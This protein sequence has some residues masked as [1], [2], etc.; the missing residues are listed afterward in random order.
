MW[1][2]HLETLVGLSKGYSY[3]KDPKCWEWFEKVHEYTWK[4]FPDKKNG[5]WFGYLNR[6]GEV[7][8]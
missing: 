7:L 6:R 3:T 5:E 8:L 2:V 4:H 1:W